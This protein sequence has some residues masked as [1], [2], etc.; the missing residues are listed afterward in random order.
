MSDLDSRLLAAHERDDRLALVTLYSEAAASVD[1]VE[2][3]AFYLTHAHIFALELGLPEAVDLR[4]RLVEMGREEP[5]GD[6]GTSRR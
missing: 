5:L 1:D 6:I 3:A 2:A 4:A